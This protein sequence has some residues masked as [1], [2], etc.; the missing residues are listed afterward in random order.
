MLLGISISRIAGI[1][2]S[3]QLRGSKGD[4]VT[5]TTARDCVYCVKTPKSD[6]N[7]YKNKIED[8]FLCEYQITHPVFK[9]SL[10]KF[11]FNLKVDAQTSD[12]F[13]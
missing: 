11:E 13:L 6:Q 8:L 10:K 1:L 5:F 7:I 2:P 12:F 4:V 9:S 3:D